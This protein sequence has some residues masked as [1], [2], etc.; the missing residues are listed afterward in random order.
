[1][2]EKLDKTD[3]STFTKKF[4]ERLRMGKDLDAPMA[5]A[6]EDYADYSKYESTKNSVTEMND[7]GEFDDGSDK[8]LGNYNKMMS[9][10]ANEEG[11]KL[12]EQEKKTVED[13]MGRMD[14][15]NFKNYV[16]NNDLMQEFMNQRLSVDWNEEY[17][18]FQAE[19]DFINAN[20]AREN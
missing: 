16:S 13:V 14:T 19:K 3:R 12:R 2:K 4:V 10:L 5:E 11:D 17:V 9:E 6:G 18:R 20:K 15:A 8:F 1:M 7:L